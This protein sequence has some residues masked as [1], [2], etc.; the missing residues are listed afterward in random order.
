MVWYCCALITGY[1]CGR[2]G[3]RATVLCCWVPRMRALFVSWAWAPSAVMAHCDCRYPTITTI[4]TFSDDL[5]VAKRS[6][7]TLGLA[8]NKNGATLLSTFLVVKILS[9][10]TLQ[11]ACTKSMTLISTFCKRLHYHTHAHHSSLLRPHSYLA[12]HQSLPAH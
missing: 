10:P 5:A 12:Y 1:C 7:S 4:F 9:V 11:F 2:E 6:C 8:C 3:I